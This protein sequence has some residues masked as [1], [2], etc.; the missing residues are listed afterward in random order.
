MRLHLGIQYTHHTNITINREKERK[1]TVFSRLCHCNHRHQFCEKFFFS[2]FYA[3]LILWLNFCRYA[4]LFF[5]SVWKYCVERQTLRFAI[6]HTKYCYNVGKSEPNIA[7]CSVYTIKFQF[8]V[9]LGKYQVVKR[10]PLFFV[11][12]CLACLSVSRVCGVF[13]AFWWNNEQ[14]SRRIRDEALGIIYELAAYRESKPTIDR[15]R[16]IDTISIHFILLLLFFVI[17]FSI[18]PSHL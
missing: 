13:S 10:Q 11:S 16:S 4:F 12:V 8:L 6:K 2:S 14:V 5:L 18:F 1:E 3:S 9:A 7:Y 15:W 17:F